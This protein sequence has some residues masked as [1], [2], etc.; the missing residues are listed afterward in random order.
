MFLEAPEER[1]AAYVLVLRVLRQA[2]AVA[3][4]GDARS[5]G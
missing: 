4:E 2:G 5:R 1:E 3:R